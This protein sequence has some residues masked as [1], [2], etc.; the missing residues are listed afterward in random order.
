MTTGT[1]TTI[2]LSQ[3]FALNQNAQYINDFGQITGF[4]SQGGAG[5]SSDNSFIYQNGV[6][7]PLTMP[8]GYTGLYTHQI[9][10]NGE[11]LLSAYSGTG[12]SETN[13]SAVWANGALTVLSI[14]AGYDPA[15]NN[16]SAISIN[17]DG[18]AFGSLSTS[19]TSSPAVW[20]NA[21]SGTAPIFLAIPAEMAFGIADAGNNKDQIVGMAGAG[22]QADLVLWNGVTSVPVDLG[23][24]AGYAIA[25]P[26][27][28]TDSGEILLFARNSGSTTQTY[29]T[30]KNGQFTQLPTLNGDAYVRVSSMNQDGQAVGVVGSSS[31]DKNMHAVLWQDGQ[32]VDLNTLITVPKTVNGLTTDGI[33]HSATSINDYGQIIASGD[34]VI[35]PSVLPSTL[36]VP[37]LASGASALLVDLPYAPFNP[38]SMVFTLSGNTLSVMEGTANLG[39]ATLSNAS[40]LTSASFYVAADAGGGTEI[41]VVAASATGGGNAHATLIADIDSFVAAQNLHRGQAGEEVA[42]YYDA[43]TTLVPGNGNSVSGISSISAG[44]AA[45]SL[46][47]SSAL[48]STSGALILEGDHSLVA[49]AS[50]QPDSFSVAVDASGTVTLTDSNTGASQTVT[51]ANYLIFDGGATNSDGSFKSI[52]VIESGTNAQIAALYNAALGRQPDLPGLEYYASRLADGEQTIQLQAANFIASPEFQSRF[53]AASLPGDNGGANDAA[54]VTALYQNVLHRA[55]ADWEIAYY[56]AALHNGEA[57][58][59]VDTSNPVSWSRAQVLINFAVSPENQADIAGWLINTDNGAYKDTVVVGVSAGA[60]GHG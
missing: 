12:L 19:I 50:G 45:L 43:L 49:A 26:V 1:Y 56:T 15:L 27:A 44:A 20:L 32:I 11:L 28:I 34:L 59:I 10:N 58:S 17:N 53:A 46:A 29:F 2:I 47:G 7:T 30:W 38:S 39:S 36:T 23:T 25:N 5:I 48:G 57:G 8:S 54:F 14:P 52:L 6:A 33:L 3:T 31:T 41:H 35:T 51:G 55:A 42:A 18:D 37:T 9:N 16:S 24:P 40:G 60:P 13:L 22:A 4:T 21:A